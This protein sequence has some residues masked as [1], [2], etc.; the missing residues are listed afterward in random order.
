MMHLVDLTLLDH[1][2]TDQAL[3]DLQNKAHL[4]AA[5]CVYPQHLAK[6]KVIL[7]CKKACVVNF[8]SGNEDIEVVLQN[9]ELAVKAGVQEI[10]YVFPYQAYLQGK[11]NESIAHCAQ[12]YRFCQKQD[13]LL[14]VIVE[15]GEVPAALLYPLCCDVLSHGC[16]FIKTSTGKTGQGASLEAAETILNAIKNSGTSSGIKVSGGIKT[17]SQAQAFIQLSEEMMQK[18]VDNQWF[19]IGTSKLL[20]PIL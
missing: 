15:S 17:I 6:L 20:L 12:V 4:V 11:K 5:L 14:K 1:Q 16:D 9:I 7:P 2:A 19:R 13:L 8:P 18:P 10:D 3:I